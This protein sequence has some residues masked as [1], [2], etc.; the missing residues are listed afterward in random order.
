MLESNLC[1]PASVVGVATVS[2]YEPIAGH[3]VKTVPVFNL[4]PSQGEP[5]RFG[6]EVIGKVPI[7]ID[8]AVRTGGDYGVQAS[9]S[10]ATETAGL[11]SS[12]VTL[13]GVPGDP[14]HDSSRGWECVAGGA[15]AKQIGKA[16]PVEPKLPHPAL[17]DAADLLSEPALEPL[18]LL[19]RS[20]LLGATRAASAPP[21]TRG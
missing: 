12:Q 20:G 14:S 18:D 9:V 21:P 4:V 7:V 16:C 6:L 17:P 10:D 15:F 2:A 8:T 11:L 3:V 13:W 1:P 19:H 5:A